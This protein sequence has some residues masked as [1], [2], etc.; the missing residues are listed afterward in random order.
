MRRSLGFQGALDQLVSNPLENGTD[1]GVVGLVAGSV[2]A[3]K[4]CFAA[5]LAV[6]VPVIKMLVEV[7]GSHG[8]KRVSVIA[9]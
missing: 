2:V 6:V 4:A 8:L 5:I 7:E 9:A 3:D 1:L